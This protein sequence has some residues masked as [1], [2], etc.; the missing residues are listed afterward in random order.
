MLK[1]L[2][3]VFL[4]TLSLNASTDEEIYDVDLFDSSIS[5]IDSLKKDG[6]KVNCYFSAG[7]Y[8]NWRPDRN[9]FTDEVKGNAMED[10]PDEQWLDIR[11][12]SLL[13]IMK[14][15]LTLAM[16]KGCDGVEAA[17]MDGYLNNSGFTLTKHDQMVYNKFID[18]EA[19]RRGLSV[20]LKNDITSFD[21]T[22]DPIEFGIWYKPSIDTSWQWQLTNTINTSYD[23]EMYDIDLYDSSIALIDSLKSNGKKV[24]C[25]FSAGSYENWRSDK[26]DF[27]DEVKGNTL[28]GWA[29]ERWLDISNESLIPIMKERLNLAVLKGCDGVEPDNMDGYTNN[30]GFNITAQDQLAYNKF[31]A[32]EARR[33]GLS[34]GL[35]N[36]LDQI[37]ELEPYFDFS[38]NEQCHEYNECEALMPFINASKP[39]FNA[40]YD[41][42]YRNNINGKR[43]EMCENTRGLKFNTLVLDVN[44]NDSF[45]YSCN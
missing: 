6:K 5:F 28:D 38:V 24:I 3:V 32:N 40:E 37:V 15:R 7:S 1:L 14:A 11:N 33:R 9:N 2:L 41:E 19:R 34:V 36:D 26:N 44:L 30:S 12:K 31:I 29:G 16:T 17:N 4:S 18:T 45:R 21:V 42:E 20:G 43:Y 13:P 23:V 8:E 35:K 39:V 10:W 22:V 25:Y 27:P